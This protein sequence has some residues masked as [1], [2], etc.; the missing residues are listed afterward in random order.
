[1]L[2]TEGLPVADVPVWCERRDQALRAEWN[3][4]VYWVEH[5]TGEPSVLCRKIVA[6]DYFGDPVDDPRTPDQSQAGLTYAGRGQPPHYAAILEPVA[7]VPLA[8]TAVRNLTFR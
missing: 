1:M 3:G 4:E 2:M 7:V 6:V 5:V 8:N